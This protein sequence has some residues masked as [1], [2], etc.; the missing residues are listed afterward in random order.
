MKKTHSHQ[1]RA[2]EAI[3]S[4]P[5]SRIL[6]PQEGGR[7]SAEILE[8]PGCFSEGDTAQGAYQNLEDAAAAWVAACVSAGTPVPEPLTNY[9]VSG[10]FAL[11]LPRSLYVRSSKAAA[12]EGVSLNQYVMN[13]VAE[14]LGAQ[15]TIEKLNSTLAELKQITQTALRFGFE[16]FAENSPSTEVP[17]IPRRVNF[18]KSASTP[19]TRH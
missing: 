5:Y 16:R 9:E 10:K 11:R 12:R 13:A 15:G 14:K 4:R 18:E 6:V 19:T 3:L 7:F 8:F 17:G 2:I 1:K